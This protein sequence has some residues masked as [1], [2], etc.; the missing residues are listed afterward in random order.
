MAW[1]TN[2]ANTVT[3]TTSIEWRSRHDGY[4]GHD[5]HSALSAKNTQSTTSIRM[6]KV[7]FLPSVPAAVP[8]HIAVIMDGNRRWARQRGLPK[9]WITPLVPSACAALVEA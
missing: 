6:T 5:V 1:V 7:S 4:N 3:P 8:Q 2:T 9:A